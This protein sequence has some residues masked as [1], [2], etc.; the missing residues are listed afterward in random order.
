MP[1]SM[2]PLTNRER[3]LHV[4]IGGR[5][6][7]AGRSRSRDIAASRRVRIIAKNRRDTAVPRAGRR[8]AG[9]GKNLRR[10]AAS[11]GVR[12]I[13]RNR[14]GIAVPRTEEVPQNGRKRAETESSMSF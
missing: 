5:K 9:I 4:P 13:T 8:N 14:R 11:R 7:A 3:E 10:I 2:R 1:K 12:I 6:A